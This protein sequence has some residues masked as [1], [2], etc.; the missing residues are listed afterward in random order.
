ML[1]KT[2][3]RASELAAVAPYTEEYPIPEQRARYYLCQGGS[4]FQPVDNMEELEVLLTE[5]VKRRREEI[6][7][8]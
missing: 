3:E 4:C 8:V 6:H 7:P 1:L 2:P 5:V